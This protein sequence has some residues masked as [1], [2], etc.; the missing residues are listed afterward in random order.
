MSMSWIPTEYED[1]VFSVSRCLRGALPCQLKLQT[2]LLLVVEARAHDA[3][4][5]VSGSACIF[6]LTLVMKN[7]EK[8]GTSRFERPFGHTLDWS[9]TAACVS[10]ILYCCA[11][12]STSCADR[13]GTRRAGNHPIDFAGGT[14]DLAVNGPVGCAG[15][16]RLLLLSSPRSSS[17]VVPRQADFSDCSNRCACPEDR[18]T[19]DSC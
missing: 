11:D 13:R 4:D 18:K 16:A 14:D 19:R 17:D 1:S 15:R 7:K 12:C 5:V 10:G 8:G 2:Y 9:T 3:L 6:G